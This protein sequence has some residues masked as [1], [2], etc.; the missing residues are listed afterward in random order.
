MLKYEYFV[1]LC[2]LCIELEKP[3]LLASTRSAKCGF[4]VL[5]NPWWLVIK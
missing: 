4:R 3:E 5:R 1:K 2:L